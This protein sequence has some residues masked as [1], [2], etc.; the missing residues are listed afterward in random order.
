MNTPKNRK[1]VSVMAQELYDEL[2]DM[3]YEDAPPPSAAKLANKFYPELCESPIE[4]LMMAALQFCPFGYFTPPHPIY[5]GDWRL[6]P[7]EIENLM[8]RR[9]SDVMICP[10]YNINNYRVD[11]AIFVMGFDKG[12]ARLVIE[13]DGHD[14]HE[15]TKEQAAKDKKR[16]RDLMLDGWRVFRF[17]GSEIFHDA[18]E[19]A[20]TID[21]FIFP[22]VESTIPNRTPYFITRGVKR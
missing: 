20:E 13:C 10:Q 3:A 2:M 1:S 15:K 18:R 16:D 8:A 5:S 22:W 11:F 9:D 17:T 6:D 4:Q 14:F 21:D 7:D 19:C 12:I